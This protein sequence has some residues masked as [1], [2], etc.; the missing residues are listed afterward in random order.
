MLPRLHK[1]HSSDWPQAVEDAQHRCNTPCTIDMHNR[2][3]QTEALLVATSMAPSNTTLWPQTF[4]ASPSIIPEQVAWVKE[5]TVARPTRTW[6]TQCIEI[7]K[8]VLACSSKLAGTF[9]RNLYVTMHCSSR[10]ALLF[11]FQP[12]ISRRVPAGLND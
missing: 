12:D 10:Y 9:A 5:N 2:D 11:S 7:C 6:H 3:K 1:L 4:L 8:L